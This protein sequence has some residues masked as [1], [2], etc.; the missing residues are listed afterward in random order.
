M[1]SIDAVTIM[2]QEDGLLLPGRPT[3]PISLYARPSDLEVGRWDAGILSLDL[4][5]GDRR[6]VP[7]SD[8]DEAVHEAAL[9]WN[10]AEGVATLARRLAARHALATWT[11]ERRH[12]WQTPK[13]LIALVNATIRQAVTDGVLPKPNDYRVTWRK[14][15]QAIYVRTYHVMLGDFDLDTIV[16]ELLRPF[17]TSTA[18]DYSA[19]WYVGGIGEN[20][21]FGIEVEAPN[22]RTIGRCLAAMD[23]AGFPTEDI[24]YVRD[25]LV[26]F[27]TVAE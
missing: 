9:T 3:P 2:A 19:D 7:C 11:G 18:R 15:E 13:Q 27:A 14:D 20:W 16:A 5:D 10:T 12:E 26:A 22:D 24:G 8:V 1:H 21:E 4:P 6:R 23:R 25:V 17:N